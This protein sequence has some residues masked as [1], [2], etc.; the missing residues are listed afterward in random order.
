MCFVTF[1]WLNSRTSSVSRIFNLHVLF[2]FKCK[3][4]WK[5]VVAMSACL[6]NNP[7]P[8][9]TQALGIAQTYSK[10]KLHLCKGKR[11]Q[12]SSQSS[13]IKWNCGNSKKQTFRE[14]A[15]LTHITNP[16]GVQRLSLLSFKIF[17]T[18][19]RK[20]YVFKIIEVNNVQSYIDTYSHSSAF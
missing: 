15:D 11:I 16:I 20:M 10:Y 3:L 18:V 4:L 13:A 7:F 1:C 14:L 17:S 2:R 12:S 9:Q 5:R 6:P 19:K 8:N